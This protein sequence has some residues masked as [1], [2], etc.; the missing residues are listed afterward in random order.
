[1]VIIKGIIE[2][3]DNT[4]K[5]TIISAVDPEDGGRRIKVEVNE[6]EPF[7]KQMVELAFFKATFMK[8]NPKPCKVSDNVARGLKWREDDARNSRR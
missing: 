2:L 8:G 7:T 4:R 1:M 3:N 5:R 6:I